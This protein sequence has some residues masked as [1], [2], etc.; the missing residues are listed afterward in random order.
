MASPSEAALELAWSRPPTLGSGRLIC[1]DGPSGS[2]KTTL[3][4]QLHRA[5]GAPVLHLDDM[6]AGWTGLRTVNAQLDRLLRPMADG[7]PGS[8][9][10][11]DW[12]AGAY[13]ETVVVE[14]VPLLVL[15]GV[16]AGSSIVADVVT[17]LVW[18]EAERDVRMARGLERDGEAFAPHWRAWAEEE[19][20]YFAAH[21]TRERADLLLS[22]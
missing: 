4:E 1:V 10:R 12:H 15:E 19:S 14:P 7:Q 17:V 2:G 6:I 22:T 16:G 20:A 8:Y 21:R 5:S 18:I 11:Y 9:R 13:A 3:A